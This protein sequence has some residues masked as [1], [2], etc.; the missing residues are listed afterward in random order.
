MLETQINNRIGY[1]TLNNPEK[2]NA[3]GPDMV[4]ALKEAIGLFLNDAEI[5]VIVLR[6]KGPAFCSGADLGYLSQIRDFSYQENVADSQSLRALFDKIYHGNKIFISEVN[7]PALAG[8][9][10]LAT[11]CDFCFATP[12]SSFGY[13]EARIGFVPALVMVYLR[14][15]ISGN[16]LRDLLLTARIL[17][18]DEAAEIQLINKVLPLGELSAHVEAFAE[19][20][21]NTT[22]GSSASYIKSLLRQLPGLPLNEALDLAAETN[23]AARKSEDC[24][25]G[26]D[27]FLNKEKI[28]W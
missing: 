3:L 5:R 12:E 23:A 22:S 1:I 18:A 21:A 8:G 11:I 10:G 24:I 16:H 25:K 17:K 6:A 13:T 26:I 7:G 4:K 15:R 19:N 9:C 20:V 14:H 28:Q 27:A 2:R